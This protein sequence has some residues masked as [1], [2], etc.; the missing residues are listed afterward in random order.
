MARLLAE[1]VVRLE[2]RV[3]DRTKEH[4]KF[5]AGCVLYIAGD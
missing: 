5:E 2:Q 4:V 1:C 3:L